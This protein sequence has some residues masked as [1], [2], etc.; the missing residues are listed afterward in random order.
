MIPEIAHPGL[1]DQLAEE[2]LHSKTLS[3][4]EQ[5]KRLL[6]YLVTASQGSDPAMLSE[7]SIGVHA[8]GRKDFNPKVDTIV[9]AEMLRLR[10]KIEEYYAGEGANSTLRIGF[11]RNSYRPI[12]VPAPAPAPEEPTPVPAPAAP[13]AEPP[14]DAAFWRG[15]VAGCALAGILGA[16]L[17]A[18]VLERRPALR[19]TPAVVAN[20]PLWSGF[21]GAR[22]QVAIATPLFFRSGQ[23]FERDFR[24]N[25]PGDLRG[26]EAL[27]RRWPAM[28]VWDRWVSYSDLATAVRFEEFLESLHCQATFVPARDLS[29]SGLARGRTIFVGHPRGAPVLSDFLADQNYRAPDPTPAGRPGFVAAQPQPGEPGTYTSPGENLL[30]N[31]DESTPDYALVTSVRLPGG[32]EVLSAFGNRMQ[33]SGFLLQRLTEPQLLQDLE[34][35]VFRQAGSRY[36]ALQIVLRVDYNKGTPTG[37]VYRRH[38]VR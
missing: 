5:L 33:T 28:P 37:A 15:V 2:I 10:R 30:E 16:L 1:L 21:G 18:W 6:S 3:R 13:P 17:F 20:H 9:R 29:A 34:S 24:L 19:E 25:Y 12:L 11:E 26:A 8:L 35:K 23:G 14:M 31:G 22:V 38:A 7:L 27:L 36:R 4:S 32:G